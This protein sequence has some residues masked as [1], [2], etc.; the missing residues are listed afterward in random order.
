MCS[1]LVYNIFIGAT[2]IEGV[3]KEENMAEK[4]IRVTGRGQV[5]VPPDR[6]RLKFSLEE[7]KDTYR[8]AVKAS[9][10]SV[11]EIR[12]LFVKQGFDGK[13]LK[14]ESFKIEAV[15]ERETNKKK[16]WVRVFKGY[17]YSHSLK[18]EFDLDHELLGKIL[19]RISRCEFHPEFKILYTVKDREAVKN[20]LLEYAVKDSKTKAEVLAK[21]ANMELGEIVSIDYSWGEIELVNSTYGKLL[22]SMRLNEDEADDY[23]CDD[24]PMQ[25]EPDDITASDTVTII[26]QL[27]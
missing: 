24:E 8:E 7:R 20:T 26:W 9:K 11:D 22:D 17:E 16:E 6:I 4:T 1:D 5:S 23:Y 2:I 19:G 12:E 25:L 27:Q 18:I 13:D 10:Q 15:F 3:Q 14:T 21:A